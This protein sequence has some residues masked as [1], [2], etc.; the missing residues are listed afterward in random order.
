MILLTVMAIK[1]LTKGLKG[2]KSEIKRSGADRLE[3]KFDINLEEV[4]YYYEDL[5]RV[6][7][8]F[9]SFVDGAFKG[10]GTQKGW[11]GS[12]RIKCNNL[13]R[14][15]RF[16]LDLLK[17]SLG[18]NVSKKVKDKLKEDRRSKK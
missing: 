9:R 15:M 2:E 12:K 8:S 1:D 10:E 6:F 16:I 5:L 14:E 11:S 3:E 4:K 17:G 18:Y 7:D 13:T